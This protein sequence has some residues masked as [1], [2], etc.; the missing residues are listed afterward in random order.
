MFLFLSISQKWGWN[1]SID[2]RGGNRSWQEGGE[3]RE[4]LRLLSGSS[5]I[6]ADTFHRVIM[7]P[8]CDV[9]S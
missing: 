9:E 2:F 3:E 7:A 4:T 6:T 1:V 5:R 8:R